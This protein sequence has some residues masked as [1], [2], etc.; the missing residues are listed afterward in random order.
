MAANRIQ[1]L[2]TSGTLLVAAETAVQLTHAGAIGTICGLAAGLAGYMY[3]DEI[4]GMVGGALAPSTPKQRKEADEPA[5]KRDRISLAY[6]LINGKSTRNQEEAEE[7]GIDT[8]PLTSPSVNPLFAVPDAAETGGVRRLSIDEIVEHC[9]ANSYKMFVGRSMTKPNHPAVQINFYKQHFRMI[10]A[11]QRGKSSMVAAFLTIV[12]RTHDPKHVRLALL[13]MEDQ[14]SNLFADLPHVATIQR[15]G[16]R[17]RLHARN[18]DQVLEYLVNVVEIM[19]YR[20]TLSKEQVRSLP[21]LL[22]YIEEFL[23]LKNEFKARVQRATSKEAREQAEA[24]YAVLVYC[25]ESLSQQGLKARV[26]L[27]LCAQVEYADDDFR[28]AMVNIGCGFSFCVRPTAAAAAGF[29]NNALL[30]RNAEDNKVGQAVVETPDCNDLVLA[31]DFDLEARLLAYEQEHSPIHHSP[32]DLVVERSPDEVNTVNVN[33][34]NMVNEP[35]KPVNALVNVGEYSPVG[36]NNSP[37]AVNNSPTFTQ[38]EEVQ[39][40]LAYAELLKANDGKPVTRTALRDALGWNNK[41]Y[42][43]LAAICDKHH[44]GGNER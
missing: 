34:V 39:V 15:D 37:A 17:V 30:K 20:Y 28:E 41:Q 35:V 2:A 8:E 16:Q 12:T 10:G 3:A 25:I 36:V 11:S 44:I 33:A 29:R 24:E 1:K 43:K 42:P 31:P 32:A 40:L 13:D 21:I 7:E 22:V 19:R 23:A 38:A 9:Q 4:V 26:Q 6:R 18:A 27:L 14:T 5:T